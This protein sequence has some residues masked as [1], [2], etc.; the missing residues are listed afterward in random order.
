MF[1]FS[2]RGLWKSFKTNGNGRF[3]GAKTQFQNRLKNNATSDESCGFVQFDGIP[4]VEQMTVEQIWQSN[5]AVKS[6]QQGFVEQIFVEHSVEQFVHCQHTRLP[7]YRSNIE[8]IIGVIHIR[9][10]PRIMDDKEITKDSLISIIADCYFVP[11]GAPLHVQ[12]LNFQRKK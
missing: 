7:V 2:S 9:R 12:R 4:T 5:L 3:L 11:S 10:I 6:V 8:N 1:L